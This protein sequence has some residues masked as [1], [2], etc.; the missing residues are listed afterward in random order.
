MPIRPSR[1]LSLLMPRS[2]GLLMVMIALVAGTVST[3]DGSLI[4]PNKM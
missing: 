2:A 4:R 3:L 1:L